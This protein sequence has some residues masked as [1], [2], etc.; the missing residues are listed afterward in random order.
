MVGPGGVSLPIVINSLSWQTVLNARFD[1]KCSLPG[2]ANPPLHRRPEP[3]NAR[4]GPAAKH[5]I[6]S[7]DR[8]AA[9]RI[10]VQTSTPDCVESV[11]PSPENGNCRSRT[12]APNAPA[13]S[14]TV[15]G[16]ACKIL[17]P[18]ELR[19]KKRFAA[20][21]RAFSHSQ[22]GRRCEQHSLVVDR[23]L[24]DRGIVSDVVR[25]RGIAQRY[26]HKHVQ[27]TSWSCTWH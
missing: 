16:G 21:K 10:G 8:A 14:P 22:Q 13:S 1:P 19:T 27:T 18:A 11:P 24:L 6:R 7:A 23:G 9:A 17:V 5:P 20:I 2:V 3:R 25:D 4:N 26:K 12:A 15:S